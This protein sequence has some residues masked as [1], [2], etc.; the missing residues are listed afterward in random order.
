MKLVDCPLLLYV[1]FTFLESMFIRRVFLILVSD[2]HEL[3]SAKALEHLGNDNKRG[4]KII[5]LLE[6][7]VMV[8]ELC[9]VGQCGK[10]RTHINQF[11][12]RETGG[13]T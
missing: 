8:G 7:A 9:C 11:I 5:I 2:C 3:D 10:N 1:T 6:A 13:E 4:N 12:P